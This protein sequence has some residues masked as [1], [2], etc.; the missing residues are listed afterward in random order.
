MR[1]MGRHMSTARDTVL[2][3]K[4]EVARRLGVARGT[5][6]KLVDQGVLPPPLRGSGFFHW[7]RIADVFQEG[8]PS[9]NLDGASPTQES[10]A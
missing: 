6:Q 9:P 3:T 1:E 2:V 4:T 7:Q 8:V 5:V 10:R